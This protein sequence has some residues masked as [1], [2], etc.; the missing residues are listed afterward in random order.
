MLELSSAFLEKYVVKSKISALR[1]PFKRAEFH[2]L[3]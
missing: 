1:D 2:T 3:E